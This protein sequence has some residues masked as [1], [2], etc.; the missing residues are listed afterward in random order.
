[1]MNELC[2]R[3]VFGAVFVIIVLGSVLLHAWAFFIVMAFVVIKG[4]LEMTGLLPHGES[5]V[6]KMSSVTLA[7][8]SYL[9]M[10]AMAWHIISF[11]Y[12]VFAIVLLLVTFIIALFSAKDKF[13]NI[14]SNN[15]ASVLFVALPSG[16]L[17]FLHNGIVD[18]VDN[19]IMIIVIFSLI[20]INDIFAYLTGIM[21]GR[22]KLFP[23]ISPK[24]T[25]EGSVGGLLFTVA[26]AYFVN[27]YL[28]QL[29]PDIVMIGMAVVI[30]VFG[31]LGDLCESMLK[32]EAGVKDSGSLIPGHG[33]ILDRFD[34]TFMAVPFLFVYLMIIM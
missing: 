29:L 21:I 4:A 34:A 15:W 26:A 20:W 25:I 30:V 16:L 9:F 23:R 5:S 32:R 1:M 8:V 18:V 6:C 22:H 19:N 27:R 31:S 7:F 10:T 2:K 33:G 13:I 17:M 11:K 24:K 3:T 12:A 28:L 14:A